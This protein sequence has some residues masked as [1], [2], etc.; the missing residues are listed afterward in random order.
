[1]PHLSDSFGS[2]DFAVLFSQ[3][4]IQHVVPRHA[5]R[6]LLGSV[7]PLSERKWPVVPPA[8]LRQ[9]PPPFVRQKQHLLERL[10]PTA[11]PLLLALAPPQRPPP[12]LLVPLLPLP[13]PP[14]SH[15]DAP[16]VPQRIA[17]PH[18]PALQRDVAAWPRPPPHEWHSYFRCSVEPSPIVPVELRHLLRR[19]RLDSVAQQH[20]PL[21]RHE[22]PPVL[23]HGQPLV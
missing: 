23:P 3:Q 19:H 17:S 7:G 21:R 4:P 10:P 16:P 9:P 6:S 20:A 22:R 2:R 12:P 14:L 18:L 11:E 8:E 5:H 15:V 13:V 1:M